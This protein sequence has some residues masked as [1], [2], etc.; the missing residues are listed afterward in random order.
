MF[1]IPRR[2]L[3]IFLERSLD[4]KCRNLLK[5]TYPLQGRTFSSAVKLISQ[6]YPEST[7]KFRLKN[8][9]SLGLIDFGN[10]K[11]VGKPLV[12]TELGKLF[13]KLLEGEKIDR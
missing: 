8:M 12:F 6:K 10:S 7:L 9:K 1:G 11:S 2:E 4:E 5:E 3:K 13:F